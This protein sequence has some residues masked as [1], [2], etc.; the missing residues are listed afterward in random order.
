MLNRRNFIWGLK[1]V[2]LLTLAILMIQLLTSYQRHPLVITDQ[3]CRP[4][5][6]TDQVCHPLV[7]ADQVCCP[8]ILIEKVC[9]HKTA[10]IPVHITQSFYT[11]IVY[12]V[13]LG[14][15]LPGQVED[16]IIEMISPPPCERPLTPFNLSPPSPTTITPKRH[17]MS[18]TV[19]K[20]FSSESYEE[21]RKFGT[22][23]IIHTLGMVTKV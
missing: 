4:L 10:F 14:F 16:I 8:Q 23:E 3:V 13:I 17:K 18:E 21:R 15:S 2:R 9:L 22:A 5:V 19:E 12:C 20:M 1:E 11:M 6:L 7:L